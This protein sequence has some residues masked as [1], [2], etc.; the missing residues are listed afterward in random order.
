MDFEDTQR[1]SSLFDF[2]FD[3]VN[4]SQHEVLFQRL[5]VPIGS[6]FDGDIMGRT[7][8]SP[9]LGKV[10]QL[11]FAGFAHAVTGSVVRRSLVEL[12]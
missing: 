6:T 12:E 7:A 9:Q 8:N 2:S 5:I 4:H 10:K 1:L 11:I 3:A